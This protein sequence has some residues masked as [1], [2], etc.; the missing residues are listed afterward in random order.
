MDIENWRFEIGKS[1]SQS[2]CL[3]V[4]SSEAWDCVRLVAALQRSLGDDLIR[5]IWAELEFAYRKE[6]APTLRRRCREWGVVYTRTAGEKDE[7]SESTA[8][9]QATT[10][11]GSSSPTPAIREANGS[12][13][14]SPPGDE[15]L[16]A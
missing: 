7:E 10:T 14:V 13:P 9:D 5:D 1:D 6:S 4:A 2:T 11:T 15:V 12:A 8:T 16:S 3:I